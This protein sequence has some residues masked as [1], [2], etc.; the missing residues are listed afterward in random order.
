M[1]IRRKL[2]LCAALVVIL[3]SATP[4][5]VQAML[6]FCS[7]V[8]GY[9]DCWVYDT[10]AQVFGNC[11]SPDPG[12]W[13]SDLSYECTDWCCDDFPGCY[14][15]NYYCWDDYPNHLE[16]EFGCSCYW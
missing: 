3:V 4:A 6:G 12:S 13:C 1:T 2:V 11:S 7:R 16:C 14:Q 8:Y 10:D 15:A 9:G 5:P